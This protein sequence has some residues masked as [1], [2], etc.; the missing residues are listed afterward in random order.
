MTEK[1]KNEQLSEAMSQMMMLIS[2]LQVYK[3]FFK[4]KDEEIYKELDWIQQGYANILDDMFNN[5]IT[6]EEI[7]TLSKYLE[8][9]T[10]RLAREK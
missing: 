1:E 5:E 8:K 10:E 6:G 9:K 2:E 4:S 7:L 3:D